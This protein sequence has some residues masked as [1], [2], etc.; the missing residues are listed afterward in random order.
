MAIHKAFLRHGIFTEFSVNNA[1]TRFETYNAPPNSPAPTDAQRIDRFIQALQDMQISTVWIQL[2]SGAGDVE[3]L[4]GRDYRSLRLALISGLQR[5]QLNWAGWG[6]CAG[7]SWVRDADLIERFRD[8][9]TM[10]AFVIDVE[11]EQDKDNWTE[12][13][14][15]TFTAKMNKLFGTENLA[16]STWSVLQLRDSATNPVMAYMKIA[17]SRVGVFAPQVYWMDYPSDPHYNFFSFEKYQRSDPTTF[18]RLV[19][20]AWES[21]DFKRPLV[22]S[23][24]AF[25]EL[26]RFWK[27]GGSPSQESMEAKIRQF[28][29][30]FTD[31][32]RIVGLNW[33]HAGTAANS[34]LGGAMSDE[35]VSCIAEQHFGTKPYKNA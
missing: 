11:P 27:D 3:L 30:Y 4:N 7:E 12:V 8:E 35:M 5:A 10:S 15:D 2:F 29:R 22:V 16:I 21:Y 20:D 18:V 13:E 9:L 6:Y 23:G 1:L 25:W 31:W 14:F 17:E 24:Q 33:Y 28:A 32:S 26:K 34:S 19:L